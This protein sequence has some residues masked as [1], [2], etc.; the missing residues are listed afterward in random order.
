MTKKEIKK[1]INE[2]GALEF[3]NMHEN[4]INSNEWRNIL[5]DMI[6]DYRMI[7][8]NEKNNKKLKEILEINLGLNLPE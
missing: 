5:L 2:K 7:E 8:F 3:I 6:F 4:E 1:Y